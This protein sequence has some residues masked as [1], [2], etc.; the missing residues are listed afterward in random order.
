MREN[1]RLTIE[2]DEKTMES[3]RYV[4]TV[5]EKTEEEMVK[6]LVESYIGLINNKILKTTR[7]L[8]TYYL[9]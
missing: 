7:K 4:A 1:N 6:Y 3:T 9:N 5:F 8:F 2:L